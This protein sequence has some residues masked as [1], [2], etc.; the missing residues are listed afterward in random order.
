MNSK[1]TP[2]TSIRAKRF[3]ELIKTALATISFALCLSVAADPDQTVLLTTGEFQYLP[4]TE[5]K[6]Q[7]FEGPFLFSRTAYQHARG[8]RIKYNIG[9]RT[10]LPVDP[11]IY[12]WRYSMNVHVYLNDVL[13]GELGSL[14]PVSRNLHRPQLW[15]LPNHLLQATENT[16]SFK[17]AVIPG[18]GYLL[19]PALGP[20]RELKPQYE[21]RLR[22]QITLNQVV[23]ALSLFI[24]VLGLMLWGFDTKNRSFLWFS[25][26]AF[27]WTI[28]SVNPFIE[29][30]PFGMRGWIW[31]LHISIDI[32]GVTLVL[33]THRYFELKRVWVERIAGGFLAV[34]AVVYA[35]LPLD[36][37][38]TTSTWV[39]TGAFL[40]LI[41]CMVTTLVISI[42]W[43]RRDSLALFASY[44]IFFAL[45]I[46]DAL[47]NSGEVE[48]LWRQSFFALNLGVP[49]FLVAAIAQLAW[50]LR[51]ANLRTEE[52]L[53]IEKYRLQENHKQREALER[54]QAANDE[55]ARIYR[56]LHDD[57]GA[58]LLDLVYLT[59]EEHSSI[60]RAALSDIRSIASITNAEPISLSDWSEQMRMEAEERALPHQFAVQWQA[61]ANEV[62]LSGEQQVQL[63]RVVRELVSNA[64]KHANA[65]LIT[66]EIQTQ[67]NTEIVF[68]DNGSGITN[69]P[70]GGSGLASIK[71][72]IIELGGNCEVVSDQSGACTTIVLPVWTAN[73]IHPTP[74]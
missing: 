47:L 53:Q 37:F 35:W 28:Y 40:S 21:Q 45:G 65:S 55:R 12:L 72:R 8:A 66:V 4:N 6:W 71:R 7:A 29:H 25:A 15:R 70:S 1:L 30:P 48:Y 24:G 68:K 59:N 33:F 51:R 43:G 18:Y 5:P 42:R 32:F 14:D 54:K 26:A 49:L 41:Y 73:T 63:T 10:N 67:E 69:P 44:L 13:I 19:P 22:N 20:Y 3:V 57:L 60:A 50:Q 16:L 36:N 34:A 46:H 27:S 38:A 2:T 64:I 58:K 23:F 62:R 31:L 17:L 61:Q 52:Q 9:E 11:A 74:Y 56:D 39:H